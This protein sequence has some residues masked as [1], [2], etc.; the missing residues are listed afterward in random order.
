MINVLVTEAGGVGAVNVIK[1]LRE[2][3]NIKTISVDAQEYAVGLYMGDKKYIVPR[4]NEPTY[5]DV[6]LNIC[7][8]E[9]IDIVFPSFDQLIPVYSRNKKLFEENE[10]RIIVNDMGTIEIA[11]DKYSTYQRLKGYVPMPKTYSYTELQ[12]LNGIENSLPLIMKP[13]KASGSQNMHKINSIDKLE[14]YTTQYKNRIGDF[15]FQ[16]YLDGTE[17]TADM[18]C[19]FNGKALA[20]VPRIRLE[21]KAG[22]S[23]KGTTVRNMDIE[24][25]GRSLTDHINFIGPLCFQARM[26]T[27]NNV[28][29]L[30]EINPRICG[31]MVFTKEAG[32]NMPLLAVKLAMGWEIQEE[33]LLYKEGVVMLRYWEEMYL[34]K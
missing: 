29:K 16:E 23:Y 2:D 21:T 18:L 1:C 31:T 5:F 20:I 3:R 8:K 15:I 4:V 33:E 14:Y 27:G 17:Y 12:K 7:K 10:I 30:F 25:I 13:K 34:N 6:I 22:V 9:K 19:D 24:K 32:V 28:I 26:D 11:S